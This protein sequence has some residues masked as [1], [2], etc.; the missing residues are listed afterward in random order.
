MKLLTLIHG[1][2]L[3]SCTIAFAQDG[4]SVGGQVNQGK[5]E[6]EMSQPSSAPPSGWGSNSSQSRMSTGYHWGGSPYDPSAGAASRGVSQVVDGVQIIPNAPGW[7]PNAPQL[8]EIYAGIRRTWDMLNAREARRLPGTPRQ[9]IPQTKLPWR[10]CRTPPMEF[11]SSRGRLDG[12]PTLLDLE[13]STARCETRRWA[14]QCRN[15]E[16]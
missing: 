13:R 8:E 1:V 12:T 6:V 16:R 4:T 15:P 9:T 10:E 11:S 14:P 5:L 3:S 2:M 7:D